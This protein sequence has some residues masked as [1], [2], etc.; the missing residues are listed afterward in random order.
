LLTVEA[1]RNRGLR[2]AGVI[3]NGSRPCVDPVAEESN[4]EELARRLDGIAVLA[5]WPHVV[6][7]ESSPVAPE[8]AGWYDL[9]V[10]S[11]SS[12]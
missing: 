5:N 4:A 7:F 8:A 9:A 1:A 6:E 10:P 12:R 11:R 3:L 2:I